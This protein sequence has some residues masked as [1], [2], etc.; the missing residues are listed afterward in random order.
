[1]SEPEEATRVVVYDGICH[2]CSGWAKF[3]SRRRLEQPFTLVPMQSEHGRSL[4]VAHGIDPEDPSSF[5]VI[6]GGRAL[7]D[8]DAVLH[9]IASPGGA[10]RLAGILRAIPQRWRDAGYRVLARNRYRWF[11]RRDTC[12]L[13]GTGDR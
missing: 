12:Y 8:S 13:P 4:L 1:M 9:V 7:T 11:G 5:L 10:W 3:L 2:I 6:D